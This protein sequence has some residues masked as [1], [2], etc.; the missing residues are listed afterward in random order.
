MINVSTLTSILESHKLTDEQSEELQKVIY[1]LN[2]G[3]IAEARPPFEKA[4]RIRIFYLCDEK[5]CGKCR[6]G[7]S[8]CMHTSNIEHALNYKSIPSAT[9]PMTAKF[10][11][12]PPTR[13]T[14][15]LSSTPRFQ[16]SNKARI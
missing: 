2:D 9:V 16:C 3:R 1:G 8:E 15:L 10:M 14:L 12:A 6:S 7:N 11:C 13:T 4:D 5:A